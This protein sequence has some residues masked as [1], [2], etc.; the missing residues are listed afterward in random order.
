AVDVQDALEKFQFSRASILARDFFWDCLCD[1]YLELVKPRVR[2][3][4]RADEARQ[5]LAFALDQ[6]LRLLH[7]FIPFITERLWRQL[8]EIVPKRGLPGVAELDTP[9]LL[10]TASYPP[11]DGWNALS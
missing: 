8:N 1:W 4:R 9:E 7:P 11:A 10:A 3:N 2:D 5:V 6:S